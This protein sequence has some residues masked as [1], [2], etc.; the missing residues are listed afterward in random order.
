MLPH[1]SYLRIVLFQMSILEIH[2]AP[3]G[4]GKSYVV[5]MVADLFPKSDIIF[6]S[7]MT[8]KALFHRQGILVIKNEKGEYE[9]VDDMIKQIDSEIEDKESIHLM[10]ARFGLPLFAY[11][12]TVV[13]EKKKEKPREIIKGLKEKTFGTS[14]SNNFIHLDQNEMEEQS[15]ATIIATPT[16]M[17][18]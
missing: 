3:T 11:D 8:D 10:A 5:T 13:S 12:A 17:F 6:L 1:L 7:A 16:T 9:P 4:K 2:N 15:A 18:D 14:K